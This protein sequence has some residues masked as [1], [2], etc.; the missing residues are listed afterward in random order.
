MNPTCIPSKSHVIYRARRGTERTQAV[1][2]YTTIRGRVRMLE[3]A[4]GPLPTEGSPVVSG[5]TALDPKHTH[6][7]CI[8]R[9]TITSHSALV[10][11][12]VSFVHCLPSLP[13]KTVLLCL[14]WL[15]EI[16]FRDLTSDQHDRWHCK[17]LV[18]TTRFV[19]DALLPLSVPPGYGPGF[20]F[21]AQKFVH[22][23]T[24]KYQAD[25]SH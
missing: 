4:Y 9:T 14:F 3:E 24:N 16:F 12:R 13:I 23:Y 19:V 10:N 11:L 7:P 15:Q 25:G 17:F 5:I 18:C 8:T 1:T 22:F 21:G 6:F 2:V 20:F